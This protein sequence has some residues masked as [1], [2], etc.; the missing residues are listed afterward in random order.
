MHQL[1]DSGIP[2]ALPSLAS[3]APIHHRLH[4]STRLPE[5]AVVQ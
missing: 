2:S 1:G 3:G 4:F 5:A